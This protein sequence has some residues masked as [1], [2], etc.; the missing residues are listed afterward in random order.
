MEITMFFYRF[1]NNLFVSYNEYACFEEISESNAEAFVLNDSSI[2]IIFLN[3]IDPK[4]SKLSYRVSS[5]EIA[6][7]DYEG[8][9]LL[10][11]STKNAELPNWLKGIILSKGAQAINTA[12]HN[13]QKALTKTFPQKWKI[14]IV[15]LGDVGSTLVTGLRLLGDLSIDRIGIFD[16]DKNKILRHLYECNQ[17]LSPF[18]T[19][20]FPD[21]M[22]IKEADIFDCDMFVF[23]V[24][25]GVPP[26]GEE[27]SDVRLAQY[28]SNSKIINAYAQKAKGYNFDGVFAV[29]SDPVD[30][31]CKSAL[32]SSNTD[33]NGNYDG[34][35]LLPDQIRGYGLGVMN[36]RAAFYAKEA[37]KA[38]HYV[39]EGRAFGPH[40]DGL[41]IADSINN[42]DDELSIYL[43]EKAQNANIVVRNLGYKPYIAPALSSAALA[44][45]DT[46]NGNW[47]YSST[48]MG[49]V[50]MG[51]KNK[52]TIKGTEVEQYLLPPL[53]KKRLSTTYERLCDF[54]E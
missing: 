17:I 31:L 52:L 30:Q 10:E 15:G 22:E 51:A 20:Y 9:N 7:I 32:L 44:I 45:I 29:V 54:Y 48:Y 34:K 38:P 39:N 6:F 24:T 49:G 41:I 40:G 4:A 42:Y 50:F 16:L 8:I 5:P 43:T 25:A 14:N 19:R 53:L 26:V 23:C 47:H 37:D 36:A 28:K 11:K 12:Y 13:W 46:I 3:N 18:D 2:N 35:G 21:V 33:I 1:N 27:L